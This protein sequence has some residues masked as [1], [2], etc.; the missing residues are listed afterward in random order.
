MILFLNYSDHNYSEKKNIKMHESIKV[1]KK[2]LKVIVS[3]I[4][5]LLSSKKG[6]IIT[7]I[8]LSFTSKIIILII[9]NLIFP[10]KNFSL[11]FEVNVIYSDF[12]KVVLNYYRK[13]QN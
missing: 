10:K 4:Y 7:Y 2:S 5:F 3:R 1:G 9:K 12:D 11:A 6:K 8:P 13:K